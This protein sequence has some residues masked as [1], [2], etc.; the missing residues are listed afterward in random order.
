[1]SVSNVKLSELK[2]LKVT[3]LRDELARRGLETKGVKDDLIARLSEA[4]EAEA[5]VEAQ[6]Q[7]AER[8]AERVDA[9]QTSE[10]VNINQ[11]ENK[12]RTAPVGPKT[13]GDGS[14]PANINENPE[15]GKTPEQGFPRDET[16]KTS[17]L[18]A[19]TEDERK[20]L[21]ADRFGTTPTQSNGK[22][23]NIGGLGQ[24]DAAEELERRKKRAERFGLPVP[25]SAA[26]EE[27]RKKQRAERFGLQVPISKDELKA[28]LEARAARF[29]L[30]ISSQTTASS[31]GESDAEARKR[32]ERAKRFAQS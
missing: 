14:T 26:E 24:F 13:A 23:Q 3:E 17:A 11:P 7:D 21:R 15:P 5:T 8:G 27:A 6:G 22:G 9:E 31:K 20:K 25:V 18:T 16:N 19:L 30:P 4:M 10:A 32:E 29:G 12:D 28:K 2:K 1:M